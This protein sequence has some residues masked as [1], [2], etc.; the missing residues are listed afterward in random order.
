MNFPLQHVFLFKSN[1]TNLKNYNDKILVLY[2][3]ISYKVQG[4]LQLVVRKVLFVFLCFLTVKQLSG[5]GRGQGARSRTT[6]PVGLTAAT[7]R[8]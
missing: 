2:T 3:F 6:W 4:I 8:H 5:H 1:N 7:V